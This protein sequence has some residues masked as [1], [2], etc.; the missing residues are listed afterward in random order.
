MNVVNLAPH[1]REKL[2]ELLADTPEFTAPEGDV[3]L[4]LIDAALNDPGKGDYRFIV[5]EGGGRVLGYACY[6]PTPMTNGCFDLYWLVVARE[7]RRTGV[8]RELLSSVEGALLEQGARLLRLE[9]A[10][11]ESYRAARSFYQ[12]SGYRQAGH[13]RDFYWPGNDLHVYVKYLRE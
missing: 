13:I 4:E 3:A 7:A 12:H 8:G 6:G 5:S 11:L 1:H 2:V 10:G 9:T